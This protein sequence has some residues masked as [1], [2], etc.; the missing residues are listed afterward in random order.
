[1]MVHDHWKSYF[2]YQANQHALCNAHHLRELRFIHEQ[3]GIQWAARMSDYLMRVNRHKS[4]IMEAG[5]N[6]F[7]KDKLKTYQAEY[8]D[9]LE[10]AK[11]EQARRGTIDSHHLLK[12][13]RHYQTETLRFMY[14]FNVPFTNNQSERDIRMEKVKQKISGGYRSL[15][16]GMHFCRIRSVLST[17][18]KN[19]K[20]LFN[21]IVTA[22]ES[23]L[24]I[25]HLLV[26]S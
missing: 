24:C 18:K 12:R 3:Q 26:D 25:N 1:M 21:S 13:L 9:I 17:A 6:Q 5:G 8:D 14:D 16:G 19:Q 15:K 11:R 7:S 2:S 23:I 4:A 10:K 20:N 22:F